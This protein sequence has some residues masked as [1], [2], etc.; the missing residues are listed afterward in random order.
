MKQAQSAVA[1]QTVIQHD[2]A[3]QTSSLKCEELELILS[4]QRILKGIS[5][6]LPNTGITSLIGP[7]GAGKSSLLR[8]ITGLNQTWQGKIVI[9]GQDVRH[10]QGGVN[11]LRQQ[12]GLIAQKPSVF[13]V[14]IADNVVFGLSR[15]ERQ[16][17]P[18]AIIQDCLEKAALWD[19]VQHRLNEPAR[20]LSLGQQQRLCLARALALKPSMLLLDEPTASLDPRSKQ[21]I[22]ASLQQLATSMP[23]LC[24]THDLEQSQRLQGQ[25]IFM[26]EGK[27]IE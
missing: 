4:K 17:H 8:C 2:P 26:C 21:L 24:V 6:C 25:V 13:P 5:F 16:Q 14:S 20:S 18:Q 10:W 27:I 9:Q 7:S 19:E 12:V 15:K 1:H 11:A 3:L 22:E 23:M